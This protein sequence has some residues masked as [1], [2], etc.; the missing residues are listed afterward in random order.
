MAWPEQVP[1]LKPEDFVVG[2]WKKG[3][4]FCLLGWRSK[5][6]GDSG[7]FEKSFEEIGLAASGYRRIFSQDTE[8]TPANRRLAARIWADFLK[9]L[10]YT[11]DGPIV[12]L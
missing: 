11:E 9:R 2:P 12:D 10:G 7:T 3:C 4:R 6:F 5:V 1:V 8:D